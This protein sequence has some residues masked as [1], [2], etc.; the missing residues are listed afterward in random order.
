MDE[1]AFQEMKKKVLD[2]VTRSLARIEDVNNKLEATD[3]YI[4]RYLP[5]NNFC[6]IIEAC[7]VTQHQLAKNAELKQRLD[8]YEK[9]KM[10]ELYSIILFDDGRA[11]DQFVKDYLV[12][13]RE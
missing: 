12:V 4:A 1:K 3:N 10:K 13:G 11:P 5:F 6:Q 9:F 7:K 8:N 2:N